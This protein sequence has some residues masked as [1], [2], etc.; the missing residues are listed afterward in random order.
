MSELLSWPRWREVARTCGIYRIVHLTTGREY[1]GSSKDIHH[2]AWVHRRELLSGKHHSPYL[3][4]TFRK[5][6]YNALAIEILEVVIDPARLLERE[7]AH[8]D[9]RKP[10]FNVAPMAASCAGVKHTAETC[11]KRS[12][13]SKRV[14]DGKTT[15]E[16]AIW[17]ERARERAVAWWKEISEEERAAI[18]AAARAVRG[19]RFAR[20]SEDNQAA[21]L[22]RLAESGIRGGA[23]RAKTIT[24]MEMEALLLRQREWR[25]QKPE[26]VATMTANMR[27]TK[28]AAG[29]LTP[30]KVQSIRAMRETGTSFAKIGVAFGISIG[31][32]HGVVMR[33]KWGDVE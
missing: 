2:R 3:L 13:A 5:Y 22:H 19:E 28:R 8:I 7:Q 33:T 21:E 32:A 29:K 26:E 17:S 14:W 25:Q 9:A 4:R 31:M 11:R 18:A 30:E 16:K 23:A 27:A 6:G 10:A 15:E 24:E 1:V 12:R 20:L